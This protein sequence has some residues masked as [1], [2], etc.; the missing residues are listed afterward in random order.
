MPTLAVLGLVVAAPANAANGARDD[1]DCHC[2]A[3]KRS[4]HRHDDGSENPARESPVKKCRGNICRDRGSPNYK[5]L[6]RF[7]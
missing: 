1:S 5:Q 4:P 2:K 6:K 3:D 7:S